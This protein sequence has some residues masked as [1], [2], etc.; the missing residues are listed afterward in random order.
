[1]QKTEPAM[2]EL[3]G[4]TPELAAKLAEHDVFTRDDLAELATDE[5]SEIAQLD[6]QAASDLIMKARAHWFADDAT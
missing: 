3:E 5:L 1:M 2:L 6:Q 4:M